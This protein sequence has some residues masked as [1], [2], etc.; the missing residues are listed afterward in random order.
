MRHRLLLATVT[1]FFLMRL[2]SAQDGS[3]VANPAI[4][5]EGYL[6]VSAEAAAHRQTRRL[7]EDDFIRMSREPGTIILDARSRQKYEELHVKGAINLSF[8]DIAVDSLNRLVPD[9]STRILIYCNNNFRGAEAAFPTKL[10]TAS[11]NISTYIALYNYGYR[12][13]YELGPLIDVKKSKL[14]LTAASTQAT[15]SASPASATGVLPLIEKYKAP[16]YPRSAYLDRETYDYRRGSG[17]PV[18]ATLTDV[19]VC[20]LWQRVTLDLKLETKPGQVSDDVI[21]RGV[22]VY[23]ERGW[24]DIAGY[25]PWTHWNF[26]RRLKEPQRDALV[27]EITEYIKTNGV[28]DVKD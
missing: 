17:R 18:P 4:D 22:N 27:K 9:K 21:R 2:A 15:R 5:I 8:P 13:V 19:L 14:E 6:R 7:S 1:I 16:A 25:R 12:N 3:G 10:P 26:I 20:D 28:R 24:Q 11:L 23:L